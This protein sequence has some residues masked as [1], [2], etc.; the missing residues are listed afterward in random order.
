MKWFE[1]YDN[2]SGG[3]T[4]LQWNRV[5]I[6][7]ECREDALQVFRFKFDVDPYIIPCECCGPAFD[8]SEVSEPEWDAECVKIVHYEEGE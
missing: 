4:V 5:Y 2:N 6:E 1:F 3:Q 8:I 7:A